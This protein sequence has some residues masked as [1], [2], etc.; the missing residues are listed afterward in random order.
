MSIQIPIFPLISAGL[1]SEI[2]LLFIERIATR[3]DLMPKYKPITEFFYKDKPLTEILQNH[4]QWFKQRKGQ[5]ADLFKANLME[6]DLK[7]A[8]LRGADLIKADLSESNLTDA[9]LSGANL[10][11]ANLKSV[12]LKGANLRGANLEKANLNETNLRGIDL[13]EANLKGAYLAWVKMSGADLSESNLSEAYLR[14]ADLTYSNMSG[15]DLTGVTLFGADLRDVTL[16]RA[17]LTDANMSESDLRGADMSYA[18][19]READ[20][21]EANLEKSKLKWA[22]LSNS[23]LVASKLIGADLTEAELSGICLDNAQL[24]E[25]IISG[26]KCTH[27]IKGEK[28]E[29]IKFIPGEFEKKYTQTLKTF[30]I[31]LNIPFTGSTYHIGRFIT[32]SINHLMS[33]SVVDLKGIEAAS[34]KD[35]KF[36][37]SIRDN[38]FFVKNRKAMEITLRDDL[39]RYFRDHPIGEDHRYLGHLLGDI[40]NGIIRS[41]DSHGIKDTPSEIDRAV[42]TDKFLEDQVNLAKIAESIY[43]MTSSIFRETEH[44]ATTL[45]L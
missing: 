40:N 23:S 2:E 12:I 43:K 8:Y 41:K 1:L 22:N 15:C 10:Y 32:T 27:I 11:G 17:N 28:R 18:D 5:K 39:N 6:A 30:E 14:G 9:N 38:D 31:I 36:M 20:L 19:L 16:I 24:S 37:I 7:G 44:S 4:E 45:T 26:V 21:S 35:T 34:H 29:M 33:S 3:G 42:M 13:V 25:W